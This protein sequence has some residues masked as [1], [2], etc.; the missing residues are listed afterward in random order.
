M[1]ALLRCTLIVAAC[2]LVTASLFG[3]SGKSDAP[4]FLESNR[5]GGTADAPVKDVPVDILATQKA[6][7][8]VSKKVTPSVVN[9]STVSR[10]KIIQPFFE[11]PTPFSRTSSTHRRPGVT[12]ASVPAS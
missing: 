9:I 8:T 12:K 6:F 3:C 4:L 11:M 10:K 5:K 7:S 2:S 1:N